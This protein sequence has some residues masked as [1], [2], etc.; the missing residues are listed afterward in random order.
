V[1]LKQFEEFLRIDLQLKQS[2]IYGHLSVA[3]RFLEFVKDKL[4][5]LTTQDI[6]DYL[7][8]LTKLDPSTY[9]NTVKSL[10]RFVRDFLGRPELMKT[11]KLPYIPFKL[12]ELP[13]KEKVKQGFQALRTKKQKLIYLLYAVTGL[14]QGE[15]KNLKISDVDLEK[16]SIKARHDSSTKR[17][18]CT[19]WNEEAD[20]LL[21]PY[22][23]KYGPKIKEEN[24]RLI[25]FSD[26][27]LTRMAELIEKKVG[28]RITPRILRSWF[29]SEMLSKGVQEVY[30]DAFCGRVPKSVLARHYTDFSPERLKEIYD[31]ANLKVLS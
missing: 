27:S 15:L 4:E 17:S 6:R 26:T 7:A 3:R 31:K 23:K 18:F 30:I 14:R 13:S 22:L 28:M 8:T 19:F 21:R 25:R 5:E 1:V 10:R 11:F 16:R 20:K 29:C 2:T 12:K 9:S 24:G